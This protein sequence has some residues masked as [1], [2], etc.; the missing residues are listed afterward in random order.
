MSTAWLSNLTIRTKLLL[1][2]VPLVLTVLV[3]LSYASL[4]M[5]RIDDRYSVLIERQARATIALARSQQRLILA[6]QELY[7]LIAETDLDQLSRADASINATVAEYLKL[8][9]DAQRYSPEDAGRFGDIL[10]F[11]QEYLVEAQAVRSK[12]LLNADTQSLDLMTERVKPKFLAVRTATSKLTNEIMEKMDKAC[13]GFTSLTHSNI[14]AIWMVMLVG[15]AVSLSLAILV[16]RRE[17]VQVILALRDSITGI[18][19][20]KLETPVPFQDRTNEVGEISRALHAL[21]EVAQERELQ[22]WVKAEA[23][24]I[25]ERL[26]GS[27]SYQAF[28]ATLLS[29][30]SESVGLLRGAVY[31]PHQNGS[32][33]ETVGGYALEHADEARSFSPGEGLVGQCA[34]DKISLEYE[35]SPEDDFTVAAGAGRVVPRRLTILPVIRQSRVAAVIELATTSA[36]TERQCALLDAL[37]PSVGVG[38]DI[39][40][41]NLETERLL[42]ETQAQAESLAVSETQLIARRN[43]LQEVLGE[44]EA[45]QTRLVEMT[46]SLP[47]AVY[48]M[49]YSPDGGRQVAF[50]SQ[51][52]KPLLG[53]TP[54]EM[55]ADFMSYRRNISPESLEQSDATLRE[56][57][58]LA[59]AGLATERGG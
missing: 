59:F 5:D 42:K 51:Q 43:E 27:P 2:L 39:L 20:G 26:Q 32:R 56:S 22:A 24:R 28:A 47:V 46:A 17:V 3:A 16:S 11:F 4:E 18:A 25:V 33:F 7:E 58:K 49:L 14:A 45:A 21:Y 52:V 37:L 41:K 44:A 54:E 36:L 1:A 13:I 57:L 50:A 48:Q 34:L 55:M 15:L 30:L 9:D 12:A 8:L 35:L 10:K 19:A 38:L 29:C 53:V 23:A 31:L 40:A 6:Q